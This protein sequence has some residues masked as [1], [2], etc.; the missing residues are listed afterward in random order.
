M[1]K[2]LW[3]MIP[4]YE[5][6]Y[7]VSNFGRVKSLKRNIILKERLAKE[8]YVRVVLYKHS[9]GK[10]YYIHRL[11]AQAFL[12][13]PN[14]YRCVNHKDENKR[15]NHAD[16]LEYCTHKYNSNYGTAKSRHREKM[17]KYFKPVYQYTLD[18]KYVSEYE[19]I[20]HASLMT[21]YSQQNIGKCCLGKYQQ[22]YGFQWSNYKYDRL[23]PVTSRLERTGLKLSKAVEQY[24]KDGKFVA[25]YPS[26]MEASRQTGLNSGGI[27]SCCKGKCKQ[28][29]GFIWKYK[30][31]QAS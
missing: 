3:R 1:N 31:P 30:E 12:E 7:M 23:Q 16:N 20:A 24:T 15:N 11:V 28:S 19:S 8:G 17:K 21:G 6:L 22:A 29:N 9:K 10:S 27:C 14:N 26:M 18:G 13:N 25:E 4:G 5:G 2:E